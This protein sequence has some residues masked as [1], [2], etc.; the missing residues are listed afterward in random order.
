MDMPLWLDYVK[1]AAYALVVI[2]LF[3]NNKLYIRSFILIASLGA[4]VFFA[5][6]SYPDK[7]IDFSWVLLIVLVN[8]AK[9]LVYFYD[10]IWVCMANENE[11]S[12]YQL[13]FKH[14]TRE[15]FRKVMSKGE[16]FSS[17]IGKTLVEEGTPV[18]HLYM[19]CK[20]L[21][22][23]SVNN[24]IVAY[25][26]PGKLIGEVSYLSGGISKAS[27]LVV[28]PSTCI[29]WPKED[30]KALIDSDPELGAAM[31]KVFST[32]FFRKHKLSVSN[33]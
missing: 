1:Y 7:W 30:L 26:Q 21:L 33:E 23:V 12:L 13:A 32:D 19:L 28:E 31:K 14:M 24:Q 20:G 6:S 29:K 15:Q 5:M 8:A 10:N 16:F 11:K 9:L 17:G 18:T 3:Y 4:L 27:V 2:A 22:A 25:C